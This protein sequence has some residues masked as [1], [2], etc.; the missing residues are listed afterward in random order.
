MFIIPY[1]A[2]V[3]AD[4]KHVCVRMFGLDEDVTL[5]TILRQ[6]LYK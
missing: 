3:V 4:P 6:F 1:L 2:S 5:S